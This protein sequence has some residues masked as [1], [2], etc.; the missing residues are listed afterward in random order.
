MSLDEKRPIIIKKVKKAAHGHHGGAWKI[1]YADFVTAMMAFFLLM[2]LLG[3][4]TQA[5][6][7]GIAEYFQNPLKVSLMG[8][9]GAGDATSIIQGGGEDLTRSTGQVKRTQTGTREIVTRV[10]E[11]ST[12]RLNQLGTALKTLVEESP[13]LKKFKNQLKIDLTSE[14]LRIQIIDEK[15]RPMFAAGSDRM[16][17][18]AREIIAEI[19]PLLNGLP[20]RISITGHTDSI[21]YGPNER[22]YTNWELSAD[23]ANAA[24]REMVR[25]ALPDDKVIRVTGLASAVPLVRDDPTSPV[26]RR[27]TIVVLNKAAEEELLKEPDNELEIG[28][29]SVEATEQEPELPPQPEPELADPTPVRRNELNP[30]LPPGLPPVPGRVETPR[31]NPS[32]GPAAE[33]S[34][35]RGNGSGAALPPASRNT[36]APAEQAAPAEQPKL[37]PLRRNP[38]NP[39]SPPI[40]PA[41]PGAD[42]R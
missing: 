24:R 19:T 3:S 21:P 31:Q 7:Q 9:S 30:V 23:R 14:G 42:Q 27:I 15:D 8:G 5:D 38:L 36:E 13:V 22:G 20:N 25:N 1:A 34:R 33:P 6:R 17:P 29:A 39:I 41:I 37:P 26:N 10:S 28:E 35:T 40:L 16:E 18:H 32:P 12:G 4:T 2:W 11:E